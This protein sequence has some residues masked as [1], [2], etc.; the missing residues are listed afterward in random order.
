MK[1]FVFLNVS[2]L[3]HSNK[4]S[5]SVDRVNK[6]L[7]QALIARSVDRE[8]RDHVSFVTL[9]FKKSPKEKRV[10]GK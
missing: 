10:S 2:T 4:P 7:A 9:R 5:S 1:I 3:R 8:K 6:Y